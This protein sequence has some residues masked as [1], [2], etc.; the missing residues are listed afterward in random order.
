MDYTRTDMQSTFNRGK[1]AKENLA[2]LKRHTNFLD[3]K[4]RKILKIVEQKNH[5][6]YSTDLVWMDLV[7]QRIDSHYKQIRQAEIKIAS[8]QKRINKAE[9]DAAVEMQ[10][11]VKDTG[12]ISPSTEQVYAAWRYLK[13]RG[14]V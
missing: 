2:Y 9:L 4:E 11:Q 1:Y 7:R 8:L 10:Q 3:D 5:W 14:I 6:G 12:L 13:T